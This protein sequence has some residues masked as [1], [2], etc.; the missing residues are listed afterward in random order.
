MQWFKH[1]TD[2]SN[3]AKIRKLIMRH[4]AVGYAVYFHCL[5]LIMSD[6][7]ESNLTFELEH[8][9]EI[10][11]DNLKIQGNSTEA[12]ADIVNSIMRTI[13]SLNLF[14]SVENKIFC[15]KLL[16]RLDSSMTSNSLFRKKIKEAKEVRS[17]FNSTSSHDAIMTQSGHN[18]DTI[19]QEKNKNRIEQNRTEEEINIKE[20]PVQEIISYWNTKS[21]L[22]KC[23]YTCANIPN[24]SDLIVKIDAFGVDIIKKAIDNFSSLWDQIPEAYRGYNDLM[25][26]YKNHKVDKFVDDAKPFD[27]YKKDKVSELEAVF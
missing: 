5:E 27:R 10:I 1:D 24:N 21:N 26:F 23:V 19:M 25:T 17:N 4:G 8:D 18:H 12:G 15:L 14:Q 3:D 9:A 20:N 11:A 6:A 13:V 2:A 7:G 22:Q 16:T